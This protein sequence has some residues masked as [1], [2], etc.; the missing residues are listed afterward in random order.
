MKL[1]SNS[2]IAKLP[3]HQEIISNILTANSIAN[4][5][6]WAA[7]GV[8]YANPNKVDEPSGSD[9]ANAAKVINNLLI[10]ACGDIETLQRHQED[11]GQGGDV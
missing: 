2:T 8:E 6:G 9:F 1:N 4:L 7:V 3:T 10:N 11:Q 5:M